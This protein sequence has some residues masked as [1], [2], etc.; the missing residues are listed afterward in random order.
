MY[1]RIQWAR[2]LTN[3][4][5]RN[6]QPKDRQDKVADCVPRVPDGDR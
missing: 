2:I 3:V 1:R 6:L 4:E 5:A